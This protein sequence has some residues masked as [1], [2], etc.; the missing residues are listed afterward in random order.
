[1]EPEIANKKLLDGTKNL[2]KYRRI[3]KDKNEQR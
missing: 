3:Y 2:T 1:M